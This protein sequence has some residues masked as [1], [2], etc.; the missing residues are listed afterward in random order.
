MS[1]PAILPPAQPRPILAPAQPQPILAP[2]QP[3]PIGI[4]GNY[5]FIMFLKSIN[6][7]KIIYFL[8]SM[9]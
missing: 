2:A 9:K 5:I 7:L 8:S 3:R 6:I 4:Q 1:T